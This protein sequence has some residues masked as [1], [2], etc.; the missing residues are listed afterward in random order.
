M[1]SDYFRE[2]CRAT[3]IS[4]FAGVRTWDLIGPECIMWSSDYPHTDSSWPNSQQVIAR[5]FA[6]VPAEAKRKILAENAAALY[7]FN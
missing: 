6:G 1:P 2:N 5:E 7:H 3:F 4:D